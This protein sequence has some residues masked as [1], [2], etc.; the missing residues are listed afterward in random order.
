MPVGDNTKSLGPLAIAGVEPY[1]VITSYSIHYTKLYEKRKKRNTHRQQNL[2]H[3]EMR[4]G[5]FVG[6]Q[7]QMIDHLPVGAKHQIQTIN[8]KVS[9]L[10]ISK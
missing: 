7:C 5:S 3:I 10:E 4:S 6:P 9:I 8:K 1:H 2:V